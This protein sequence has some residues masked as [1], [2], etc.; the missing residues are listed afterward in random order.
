MPLALRG[1][2]L[3]AQGGEFGHLGVGFNR[4]SSYGFARKSNVL[5]QKQGDSSR[6]LSSKAESSGLK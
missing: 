6:K 2:P 3:F 5:C 1:F 4:P